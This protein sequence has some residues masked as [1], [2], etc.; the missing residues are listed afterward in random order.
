M[1]TK[2]RPYRATRVETE[3]FDACTVIKL[4]AQSGCRFRLT[5]AG[6]L[7]VGEL[8][9]A[10]PE[11]RSLFLNFPHPAHLTIAAKEYLKCLT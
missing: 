2:H 10:A 9:K 4:M 6:S 3:V 5:P 7:V 1:R 11:L 8:G